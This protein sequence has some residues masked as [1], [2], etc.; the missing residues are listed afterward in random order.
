MNTVKY[1]NLFS[2]DC[3]NKYQSKSTRTTYKYCVLKFLKHFNYYDR[4]KEIPN[5]KI[6][7]WLLTFDTLNTRKQMLCSINAFY[8]LTAG[9]PKKIKS[10]PYPRK[11]KK[12]PR[13]IDKEFL[14][15]KISKIKNLKHK[16]I[17]SLAYSVGL[18][19]SDVINL[20]IKDIDSN[21]M[22]INLRNG[23]GQKDRIV[24]LSNHI[25]SLL[26]DYFKEYKP[27]I[28]LF[29]GQFSKQYTTGSCNKIVKKYIGSNEHFHTL[30]HSSAT[31]MLEAGTDL[32]IIKSILG[33]TNIKTTMIYTHISNE[34]L[35]KAITP[36]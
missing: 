24:P 19:V 10:I 30:R 13:V 29:N 28:Y 32:A 16:A 3:D 21:R 17:I 1:N 35:K 36:L 14:L 25:L 8:K 12:L 20:N 33:H 22:I 18:R 4:P 2:V 7:E 11:E 31:S 23:K 6:K 5:Q 15:N 34:H 27:E 26:R 9:M